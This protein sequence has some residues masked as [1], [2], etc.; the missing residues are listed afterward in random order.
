MR[1]GKYE[2]SSLELINYAG[3]PEGTEDVSKKVLEELTLAQIM[4]SVS[5]TTIHLFGR[6]Y[7]LS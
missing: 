1:R 5:W 3:S 6:R 2:T 7:K 4:P